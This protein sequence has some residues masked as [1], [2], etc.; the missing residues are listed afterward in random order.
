MLWQLWWLKCS[1]AVVL[2]GDV[3]LGMVTQVLQ[4][5]C[6]CL[7]SVSVLPCGLQQ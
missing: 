1:Q 6:Q 7:M 5:A 3:S 4:H 2:R